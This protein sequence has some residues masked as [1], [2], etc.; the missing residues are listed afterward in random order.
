MEEEGR[1]RRKEGEGGERGRGREIEGGGRE[2]E[3]GERGRGGREGG[4]KEKGRGERE[5]GER[6]Q[7][8]KR[9]EGK[10]G[11]KAEGRNRGR[12]LLLLL[13]LYS[14][15]GVEWITIELKVKRVN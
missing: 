7:K 15:D 10:R 8:R 4:G 11:G 6:V 9:W 2:R 3:G 12:I 5:R 13:S 1:A 14:S